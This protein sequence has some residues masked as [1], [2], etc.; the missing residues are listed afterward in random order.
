MNKLAN[1]TPNL[2]KHLN[3]RRKLQKTVN[4]VFNASK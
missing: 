3:Q 2:I 4:E 1:F